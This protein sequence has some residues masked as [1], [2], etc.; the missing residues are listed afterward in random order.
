MS[1]AT[2]EPVSHPL[3]GTVS[4]SSGTTPHAATPAQPIPHLVSTADIAEMFGIKVES[5]HQ[6]RNRA[7]K[8]DRLDRLP[9]PDVHLYGKPIWRITTIQRWAADTGRTIVN[10]PATPEWATPA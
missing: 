9:D 8:T 2:A 5:V 1:T 7:S 10:P 3:T 4:A 6:W